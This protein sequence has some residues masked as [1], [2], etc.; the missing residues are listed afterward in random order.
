MSNGLQ[1]LGG[2]IF[3]ATS[4]EHSFG[5]DAFLLA[6]FADVRKADRLLIDLGTGCGIIPML[7]AGA[8]GDLRKIYGLE[9]QPKGIEQFRE[10]LQASG[11][12]EGV[13]PV[14]GDLRALPEGLPLGEF[15][16]VSCNPPYQAAGTGILSGS[17]PDRLARH[18]TECTIRDVCA[19]AKRLLRFG[20]RLCVC[21]RPERLT[22]VMAAMRESGIEP[23]RL[24]FVAKETGRAP[25]LFLL[26]GKRGAHAALRVE[27][28]LELYAGGKYTAEMKQIYRGTE[29]TACE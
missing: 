4:P 12:L 1:S 7:W 13:V 27:P 22:D 21:Q 20:G 18:E 5:T 24:R 17:M 28:Q 14:Q 25:W 29:Y 3:V 11:V 26:E 15:D 6:R 10:S 16:L 23:K 8:G 19:A 9:L 2:G